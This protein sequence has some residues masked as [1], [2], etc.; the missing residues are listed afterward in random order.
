MRKTSVAVIVGIL[1]PH[2]VAVGGIAMLGHKLRSHE[3]YLSGQL[4]ASD[5]AT[6]VVTLIAYGLGL[7]AC[8]PWFLENWAGLRPMGRMCLSCG[9]VLVAVVQLGAVF[10]T[11]FL[12][13][14]YSGG[15]F[16]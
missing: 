4:Q 10:V 3:Y 14:I 13:Y 1:F 2:V 16:P 12:F 6:C 9:V 11:R 8:L 5:T 15:I 7:L